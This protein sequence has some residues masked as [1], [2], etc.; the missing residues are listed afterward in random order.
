[1]GKANLKHQNFNLRDDKDAYRFFICS[2]FEIYFKLEKKG[3]IVKAE[4]LN[5]GSFFL[6]KILDS[7]CENL[8]GKNNEDALYEV[9]KA[10]IELESNKY[11]TGIDK[12]RF[13][14]FLNKLRNLFED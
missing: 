5:I 4:F 1:M 2:A 9:A 12:T 8:I 13:V 3:T 10:Q 14:K 7:L 6:T 11:L